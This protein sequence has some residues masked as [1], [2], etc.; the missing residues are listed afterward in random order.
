VCRG[1]HLAWLVSALAACTGE[2]APRADPVPQL[3]EDFEGALATFW[4][5]GDHGTGRV[6][7]GAVVLS[8]ERARSGRRSARITVREGDVAQVG[9]SGQANERAELDSGKHRLLGQD[10]WCGFAL[11]VPPQ[12]P[13]TGT[14]LVLAQWKQSGLEGSPLIAQ[15]YQG[16]RHYLTIRDLATRGSWRA[17]F[18]LPAIVPGRWVDLVWHVR[19]A[20]DATG[21]VEIW[22]DGKHVVRC[23]GATASPGGEAAFYHKVG[24]YR[25]RMAEPMT[26]WLDDYALGRSFA[27]VDPARR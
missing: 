1:I 2:R 12:F 6:A 19:F 3:R 11:L 9:D 27:E 21:L 22:M 18:E 17:T 20:T 13:I 5:P 15:R 16:G 25:D 7:P 8:D 14:R 24:L 23:P 4:R 26:I 10:V